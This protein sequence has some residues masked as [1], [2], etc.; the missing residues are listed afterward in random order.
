MSKLVDLI[1]ED[2]ARIMERVDLSVFDGREVL[3][4]GA[5]GLLGAQV[6]ACFHKWNLE[7]ARPIAVTLVT[8]SALPTW[9]GELVNVPGLSMARGDLTD[10]GFC[11]WL[12][13]ADAIIHA[14]GYAQPGKFL[15]NPAKTIQINTAATLTLL[16]KLRPEG[17]FLFLSSS[18]VYSG[19]VQTP[20]REDAIGTTDPSHPRAC[21][22]EGKR[23]GE[24][25]CH[26]FRREGRDVKIGRIALTYGPGTQVDDVRVL[27]TLIRQGLLEGR[28][29]L[30]DQGAATRTL[31]YVSDVGELLLAV[32]MSGRQAVYNIGGRSMI[33][34]LG[35]AHAIGRLVGVPVSVPRSDDD[36]TGAAAEV[37][38][39]IDR[40]CEEFGKREFVGLEDGL[41]RTV[42]WQRELYRGAGSS[43]G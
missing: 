14:A 28:I 29:S 7:H 25:L 43:G 18:E 19:C 39:D 33:T 38:L 41:A 22:I 16:E 23:C 6:L 26:A 34:I 9:L 13:T 5:S 3:I 31:G 17:N 42:E 12:P 20:Y 11:G 8:H 15:A 32:L 21:Y 37:D 10:P 36:P 40:A 4:T 2:A 30:R 1:L 35:L 24:A 27:N